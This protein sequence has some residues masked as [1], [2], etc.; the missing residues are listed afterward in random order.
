MQTISRDRSDE[1]ILKWLGD[2]HRLYRWQE[3]YNALSTQLAQSAGC[4]V[5]DIRSQFLQSARF[6]ALLSDDGI[7]PS[8][9]GHALLHRTLA[10]M[11]AGLPD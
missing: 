8:A 4:P 11:L 2:V 1:N 7:H 6:P 3:Y 9:E 10:S 5:L